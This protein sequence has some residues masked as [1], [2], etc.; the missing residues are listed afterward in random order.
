VA[1]VGPIT[2]LR[3]VG[4]RLAGI[5]WTRAAGSLSFTTVL[6]LVPLATVT[7]AVVAEFPVFQDFVR[8]LENY[9]L[10]YMLPQDASELVQTYVVGLATAAANF[11][12]VWILFVIIT[13]ALV[14][15]S[16]ESEI[17]EIWGLRHKRPLLR[18][19]L[20][21][22]VGVVAGPLLVGATIMFVRWLLFQSIAAVSLSES[23]V[24]MIKVV[25]PFLIAVVGFTLLYYVA[26]ACS[27]RWQHALVSGILAAIAS[28]T[29]RRAFA[30]Y[31]AHS[32]TYEIL[33]GA[34]AAFPLFLL[35]IFVFWM[36]VL[37]GAAI[38][39]SLA[40]PEHAR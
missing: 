20:V 2:L 29:T 37:A 38:T 14:V 35:W 26:P 17:N 3:R 5:G 25:V 13:A 28:E 39:A 23:D 31:V 15:D 40:D 12:G 33:Y 1:F 8:I 6:G 27:V 34:L 10:R 11:K 19:V 24:E 18:R 36:I 7:F 9:L 32:P 16:V 21:Y 4:R 30:W 22:T